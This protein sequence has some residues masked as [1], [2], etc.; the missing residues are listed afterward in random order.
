MTGGGPPTHIL[1]YKK[2][3]RVSTD[4]EE[5]AGKD[6]TNGGVG[7]AAALIVEASSQQCCADGTG[8]WREAGGS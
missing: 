6:D 3:S 5:R 2:P 1:C 4:A 7:P 8:G